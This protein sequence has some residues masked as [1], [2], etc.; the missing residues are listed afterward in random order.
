LVREQEKN[1]DSRNLTMTNRQL[2]N[3]A[4][5]SPEDACALAP[6]EL[7]DRQLLHRFVAHFDQTAFAALV[8]RHGP[9]V[10]G[11]CR[12]VLRD[13][14]GAEDAFQATFLV[15][16]RKARYIGRPELLANWLFG[17]AYRTALKEKAKAARRG[18]LERQGG[19]MRLAD[20]RPHV[21]RPDLKGLLD[22]ELQFL[23]AKYRAPLEGKTNEQAARELGWPAGSM[24]GRLAR[25]RELLRDR[26]SA[27][28]RSACHAAREAHQLHGL[29]A[30]LIPL[31]S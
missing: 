9:M 8:H 6:K 11:V 16:V 13:W 31:G 2:Q 20:V 30:D 12:R 29:F 7:T 27:P 4:P 28:R 5:P 19:K 1:M 26:W 14:H 23:P 15:L 22:E 18:E 17:V 10:S 25:G 3:A 24:S 21:P